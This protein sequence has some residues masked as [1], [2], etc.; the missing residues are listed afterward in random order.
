[1]LCIVLSIIA[2]CPELR[3]AE[4]PPLPRADALKIINS[5]GYENV[6][7]GGI[8]Q[9]VGNIKMA[10][11]NSSSVALVVAYGEFKGQPEAIQKTF[12]YDRDLGW[13]FYEIDTNG[14]RVRLWTVNGYSEA[15]PPKKP[16]D[17]K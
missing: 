4:P 13:F 10:S 16:N 8:I 15:T 11:L 17:Q 1:M 9:G 14:K 12:F 5:L 6:A 3:A 2:Y 7:I